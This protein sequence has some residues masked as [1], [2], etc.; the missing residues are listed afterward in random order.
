MCDD[1]VSVVILYKFTSVPFGYVCVPTTDGVPNRGKKMAADER[2]IRD[3]FISV[4]LARG[5]VT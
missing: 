5:G 2:V 4:M 3:S 1:C